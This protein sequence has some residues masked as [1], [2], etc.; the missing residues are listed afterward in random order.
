MTLQYIEQ[1]RQLVNGSATD[2]APDRGNPRV[3][4]TGLL[5]LVIVVH[6][7]GSKL[8][9]FD[10]LSVPPVAVLFEKY[11]TMGGEFD[12]QANDQQ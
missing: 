8:P 12:G 3:V 9:D 5:H 7:H 1:L 11:R 2:K 10:D 6:A 4:T